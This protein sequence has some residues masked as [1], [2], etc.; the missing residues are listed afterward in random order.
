M[1]TKSELKQMIEKDRE[2]G[3]GLFDALVDLVNAN[4]KLYPFL[5][6]LSEGWRTLTPP[7]SSYLGAINSFR[8]HQTLLSVDLTRLNST[9]KK[10]GL[11]AIDTNLNSRPQ[12]PDR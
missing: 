7:M 2:A 12:G 10:N 6:E 5:E 1:V 3:E 11:P 4:E 8:L 9:L